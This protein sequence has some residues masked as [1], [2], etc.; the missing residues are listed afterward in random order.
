LLIAHFNRRDLGCFQFLAGRFLFSLKAGY[1][2]EQ[3]MPATEIPEFFFR[4]STAQNGQYAGG[5][6]GYFPIFYLHFLLPIFSI[7][8]EGYTVD[9]VRFLLTKT[10]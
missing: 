2:D 6:I 5:K 8:K 4:I 10:A 7:Q 9:N 3:V 1:A